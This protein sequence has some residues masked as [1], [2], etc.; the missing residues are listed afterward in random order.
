MLDFGRDPKS[1][2]K[3]LLEGLV[4]L[5]TIAIVGFRVVLEE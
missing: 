5:A 2:I 4:Y 1:P 3:T